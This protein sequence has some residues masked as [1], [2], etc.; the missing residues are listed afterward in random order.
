MKFVQ[1]HEI[2]TASLTASDCTQTTSSTVWGPGALSGRALKAFGEM[3]LDMIMKVVIH[4]R[5]AAIKRTFDNQPSIFV[6]PEVP[7]D[8]LQIERDLQELRKLSE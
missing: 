5:L 8:V 4:R 7:D 3:S 2:E 1:P 6:T